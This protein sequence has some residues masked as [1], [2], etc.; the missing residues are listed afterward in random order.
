MSIYVCRPNVEIAEISWSKACPL[1]Y[2]IVALR[3][4]MFM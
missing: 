1:D 3:R 2:F 4:R